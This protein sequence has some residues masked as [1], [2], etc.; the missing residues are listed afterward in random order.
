MALARTDEFSWCFPGEDASLEIKTKPKQKQLNEIG[1]L[2]TTRLLRECDLVKSA[3]V[4]VKSPL[5]PIRFVLFL[6]F[7]LLMLTGLWWFW[8]KPEQVVAAADTPMAAPGLVIHWQV[9]QGQR[10]AGPEK[11]AAR[12]GE[13]ITL[14]V[15][16]D[17]N[18]SLH[19]HGD[20]LTLPIL[21]GK[22]MRL[23]WTPKHSGRFDMELHDSHTVLT[24]VEVLPR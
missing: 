19:I 3:T 14:E 21:A 5:M 17:R 7:A 1:S 15:G 22:N 23:E 6:V 20:D 10:V 9:V 2:Q 24:Q 4:Y 12:V 8:P 13:T 11:F 16:S 18:D